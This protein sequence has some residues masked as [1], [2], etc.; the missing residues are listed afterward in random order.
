M[1]FPAPAALL[2][3][4][5]SLLNAHWPLDGPLVANENGGWIVIAPAESADGEKMAALAAI[6]TSVPDPDTVDGDPFDDVAAAVDVAANAFARLLIDLLGE[7]PIK[8]D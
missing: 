2:E 1:Q 3:Q 4:A 6:L 7:Q 5:T 8:A